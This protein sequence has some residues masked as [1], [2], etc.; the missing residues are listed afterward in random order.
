MR[1]NFE[2]RRRFG[3]G[4]VLH[5]TGESFGAIG[6]TAVLAGIG[7]RNVDHFGLGKAKIR[8]PAPHDQLGVSG[9]PILRPA[10]PVWVVEAESISKLRNEGRRMIAPDLLLP[11]SLVTYRFLSS[12]LEFACLQNGVSTLRNWSLL[13]C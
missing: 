4:V 7:N 1:R 12:G 11:S 5:V 13:M 2:T 3:S 8:D 9:H 6:R 10:L